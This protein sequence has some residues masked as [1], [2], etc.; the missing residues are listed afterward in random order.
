MVAQSLTG[1][2]GIRFISCWCSSWATGQRKTETVPMAK[3][4]R[5]TVT[6]TK[7]MR[8]M[9]IKEEEVVHGSSLTPKEVRGAKVGKA[10]K[11][12]AIGQQAPAL[13]AGMNKVH[14]GNPAGCML[15][16]LAALVL[17]L[18]RV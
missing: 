13:R 2:T 11:A 1:T 17:G 14:H 8:R 7:M 9:T 5:K 6:M 10:G 3:T 15:Q 18:S 12:E 4:R 16:Q